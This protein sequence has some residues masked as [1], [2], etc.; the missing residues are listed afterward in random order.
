MGGQGAWLAD[1]LVDSST[2]SGL[3]LSVE[4]LKADYLKMMETISDDKRNY[5]ATVIGD[6]KEYLVTSKLANIIE[7]VDS[8]KFANGTDFIM[9]GSRVS[10]SAAYAISNSADSSVWTLDKILSQMEPDFVNINKEVVSSV[11]ESYAGTTNLISVDNIDILN[12]HNVSKKTDATINASS[13]LVGSQNTSEKGIVTADHFMDNFIVKDGIGIASQVIASFDPSYSSIQFRSSQIEEVILNISDGD[14]VGAGSK[15]TD[16]VSVAEAS[17]S[18][19]ASYIFDFLFDHVSMDDGLYNITVDGADHSYDALEGDTSDIIASEIEMLLGDTSGITVG[20]VAGKYAV[21]YENINGMKSLGIWNNDVSSGQMYEVMIEENMEGGGPTGYTVEDTN[22]DGTAITVYLPIDD[23]DTT[24]IDASTLQGMVDAINGASFWDGGAIVMPGEDPNEPMDGDM[25]AM[26]ELAQTTNRLEVGSDS[27][28][29]VEI[30][31]TVGGTSFPLLTQK[32]TTSSY[33]EASDQS[34][35]VEVIAINIDAVMNVTIDG[36]VFELDLSLSE[37]ESIVSVQMATEKLVELITAGTSGA[38]ASSAEGIISLVSSTQGASFVV[39]TSGESADFAIA[40]QRDIMVKHD[41]EN[42]LSVTERSVKPLS[43]SDG[44]PSTDR[45]VLGRKDV[46]NMSNRGYLY[47]KHAMMWPNI[48]YRTNAGSIT[49]Q[50]NLT[51]VINNSVA[52]HSAGYDPKDS[53]FVPKSFP[54]LEKQTFASARSKSDRWYFLEAKPTVLASERSVQIVLNTLPPEEFER[55]VLGDSDTTFSSILDSSTPSGYYEAESISR[56]LNEKPLGKPKCDLPILINRPFAAVEAGLFDTEDDTMFYEVGTG[57]SSVDILDG[58]MLRAILPDDIRNN[59]SVSGFNYLFFI[60]LSNDDELREQR[61]IELASTLVVNADQL[62]VQIVDPT[63][64]SYVFGTDEAPVEPVISNGIDGI[65]VNGTL[66]MDK[67]YFRNFREIVLN[68]SDRHVSDATT[69]R[70]VSEAV[71]AFRMLGIVP[72]DEEGRALDFSGLLPTGSFVNDTD[73]TLFCDELYEI[74]LRTGYF[75]NDISGLVKAF[76][77][78]I[79]DK[80]S[81]TNMNIL[82]EAI[83]IKDD[84]EIVSA[85]SAKTLLHEI[86]IECK[87]DKPMTNKDMMLLMMPYDVL[88]GKNI[89]DT[90]L[91]SGGFNFCMKMFMYLTRNSIALASWESA[92]RDTQI[93]IFDETDSGVNVMPFIVF[94]SFLAKIKFLGENTGDAT[95]DSWVD[96]VQS[97]LDTFSFDPADYVS[98]YRETVGHFVFEDLTGVEFVSGIDENGIKLLVRKRQPIQYDRTLDATIPIDSDLVITKAELLDLIP[99]ATR[100]ELNVQIVGDPESWNG[101][102]TGLVAIDGDTYT[103][104]PKYVNGVA[105]IA[106]KVVDKY[107]AETKL[108]A[109]AIGE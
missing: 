102:G 36:E 69:N 88:T 46:M 18:S 59:M 58:F 30:I 64:A 31:S 60:A 77:N 98:D 6:N 109:M 65:P 78:G 32:E 66:T 2:L 101:N 71:M 61:F 41:I 93:K 47:S 63:A 62:G 13:M 81:D 84:G 95:V 8:A 48:E 35:T 11:Q 54:V 3:D 67:L 52:K 26:I 75:P 79:S 24:D 94:V 5:M 9:T 44:L 96:L 55:I 105:G 33:S 70:D 100:T 68:R 50:R 53:A 14:L 28:V 4:K 107:L 51:N 99:S 10:I 15:L 12:S 49:T 82:M 97:E 72:E 83:E 85:G 25:G 29:P 74:L 108:I 56:L 42:S 104:T 106:I 19:D 21:V 90:N 1:T 40:L 91:V 76:G 39:T 37:N 16:Y 27:S 43:I 87:T 89:V 80:Y 57:H 86:F 45:T 17:A 103:L 73:D 7:L 20:N 38:N 23:S 92:F 34:G 22:G